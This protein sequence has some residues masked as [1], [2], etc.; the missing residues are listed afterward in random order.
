MSPCR[1]KGITKQ[2]YLTKAPFHGE[3]NGTP[4]AKVRA[5]SQTFANNL[6][7]CMGI[8]DKMEF[9]IIAI[10]ETTSLEIKATMHCYS[11]QV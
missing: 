8:S 1:E 5:F 4:G 2:G 7:L 3:S 10:Y 9:V 11:D 6:S